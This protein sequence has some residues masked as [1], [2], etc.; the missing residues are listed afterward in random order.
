[1]AL[2][3]LGLQLLHTT[4]TKGFAGATGLRIVSLGFPD[5]LTS[6]EDIRQLFGDA[7]TDKLA[8]RK[9]SKDILGWHGC[10]WLDQVVD[11]QSF[12]TALGHHLDAID[13]RE[14]RGGEIVHD[15]NEPLPEALHGRYDIL[16]DPGTIEH[17]FNVAEAMHSIANLVRVGGYVIQGVGLNYY[18]HGFYNFSPTFVW[19]F[20]G[21]NGFELMWAEGLNQRNHGREI[22]KFE[23]DWVGNFVLPASATSASIYYIA[24]RRSL[25]PISW[26]TQ[27][28]YL[29]YPGLK[30]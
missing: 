16:F 10:Q 28:K 9:D 4:L 7:V 5:M 20:F 18:N 30:G 3:K 13:R 17:C 14:V 8:F 11:T 6:V 29:D 19:D 22:S 15:L 26:P 25:Q 1:M 23:F 27:S 2:T 21:Q 24:R 12:F